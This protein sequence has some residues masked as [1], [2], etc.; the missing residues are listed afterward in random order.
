M[1]QQSK[2]G[3]A[4]GNSLD[5]VPRGAT[6]PAAVIAIVLCAGF[7]VAMVAIWQL[8]RPRSDHEMQNQPTAEVQTEMPTPEPVQTEMPAP[9]AVSAVS[10]PERTVAIQPSPAA[11]VSQASP[12]ARQLMDNQLNSPTP[13]EDDQSYTFSHELNAETITFE[14]FDPKTHVP[15]VMTA[16]VTGTFRGKPLGKAESGNEESPAGSHLHGDQQATFSFVSN[17]RYAPSYSGFVR[18][19]RV[20]GDTTND[21][22]SCD[23][24]LNASGSDGSSQQFVLREVVTVTEDGAEVTFSQ[25]NPQ[26]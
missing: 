24:V 26:K 21:S 10:V 3:E 9:E 12:A 23:F 1:N 11:P 25:V 20:A 6:R 22:I 19:L 13:D 2:R 17:D 18:R 8:R 7:A 16:T 5:K 4:N 15:G 14:A